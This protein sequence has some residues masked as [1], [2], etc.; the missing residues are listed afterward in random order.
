MK[1]DSQH[2]NAPLY[3][4]AYY[5]MMSQAILILPH[6]IKMLNIC[7]ILYLTTLLMVIRRFSSLEAL[8][9]R[10]S[11]QTHESFLFFMRNKMESFFALL[12]PI[13]KKM[14][15]T[16]FS[17]SKNLLK[18]PTLL[19]PP[20]VKEYIY[21]EEESFI[22]LDKV[23]CHAC[24]RILI[25]ILMQVSKAT[26]FYEYRKLEF[27]VPGQDRA[28]PDFWQQCRYVASS[29]CHKSHK[30]LFNNSFGSNPII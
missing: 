4:T 24:G 14:L 17:L 16:C 13:N 28:H 11:T 23:K 7:C 20:E 9:I 30:L 10:L 3:V 26:L 15:Y 27:N 18:L 1:R 19:I 21:L 12:W 8:Q 25:R 29:G 2:I 22:S 5:F 6:Y